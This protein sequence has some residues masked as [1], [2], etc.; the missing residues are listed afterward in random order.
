MRIIS[1][2][3]NTKMLVIKNLHVEVDGKEILHDVSLQFEKGKVHAIM[4][5]NGSGKSTLANVIMG[6]PKY[7]VTRGSIELD[8]E[9]VLAMVPSERAQKGL[10]LSFQNPL[11][12]EGVN[13]RKFLR[14]IVNAKREEKLSVMGFKKLLDE[15]MALLGMDT[16][17]ASRYLN[18]GFSGGEKKKM[19]MLQM[20]LLEP[21]FALLDET[22]SGLD[23][24]AIKIVASAINS[25]SEMGVIVITHYNK[26]LEYIKPDA[27]SVLYKGRVI[28]S[29]GK[30]LAN[31]IEEKG[32]GGL[33]E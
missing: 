9:D 33:Y 20:L 5:P 22:D 21:S 25:Q 7:K 24:D 11:E 19:E 10:F 13:I 17:F 8:G 14:T 1:I 3:G 26:F 30:E 27:V 28:A 6:H 12:V 31:H 23:A 16:G 18:F 4:G 32:F 15:K 2:K 29:G